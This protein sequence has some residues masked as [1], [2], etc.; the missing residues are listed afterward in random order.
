M[1]KIMQGDYKDI[2]KP[3][4]T[5]IL[6]EFFSEPQAEGYFLTGGTALAAFYLHHRHSKDLDFFKIGDFD[7][8]FIDRFVRRMGEKY[9]CVV[10][11]K[12]KSPTYCEY[13][14]DNNQAGWV[15]RLDFVKEQPVRFGDLHN[16]DGIIYDDLIN[17]ATNKICAIYGRL[18]PKDYVDLYLI[19]NGLGLDFET[20]FDLAKQKDA[21]LHEF[22]FANILEKISLTGL[23]GILLKELTE[24]DL[25]NFYDD[26]KVKLLKKVKPE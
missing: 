18:E 4:Q 6:K 22:Y 5:D 8:F 17:I 16:Q 24:D 15:Q 20:C 13:Y 3:H 1:T 2:L 9:D 19:V 25:N 23:K 12:V 26:I 11:G 7:T 14:L 10:T 21:G